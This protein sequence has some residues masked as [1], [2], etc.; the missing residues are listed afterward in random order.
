MAPPFFEKKT[1]GLHKSQ[2]QEREELKTTMASPKEE[3]TAQ[4]K[5]LS[6]TELVQLHFPGS[7]PSADVLKQVS[8]AIEVRGFTPENT[9]FAQSVCP[10][11][12]NHE[13]GDITNLFSEYLGE[14]FHLGGLAGIPFT[15]KTGFAAFSHHV[16]DD[17]HC[18]V[19]MAPHIGID[20]ALLLGKYSRLGQSDA[21][22]A[23][24]AA[25]GAL[26]HCC[27]NKAIPDAAEVPEDYQMAYI[28][29]EVNRCKEKILEVAKDEN[30]KQA[31]LARQMHTIANKMLRK[32]VN[33]DFGSEQS[34]LAILTGI[35]IN[36]PEPMEDY[37]QPLSFYVM[38][39]QGQE[40]HLFEEAFGHASPL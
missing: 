23:C 40:M 4:D 11:E 17:G 31:E 8:K 7:L 13:A 37:F 9:L 25:V 39:K 35:Q 36:M 3:E 2:E 15:G 12:I 14:V 19:L 38:D 16:P 27:A 24:G 30:T 6:V 34:T 32:I 26:A 18:F 10:D 21:G 28:I 33:V 5:A 22:S 29:Q 1:R 20:D